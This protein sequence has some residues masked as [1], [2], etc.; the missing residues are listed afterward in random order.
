MPLSTIFQLHCI[1]WWSLLLVE[2]TGVPSENH[3]PFDMCHKL[4]MCNLEKETYEIKQLLINKNNSTYFPKIT[5]LQRTTQ[6]LFTCV[7]AKD[8]IQI[9]CTFTVCI[10]V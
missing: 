6:Y 4:Y 8:F 10:S 2:E 1:S 9:H 3:G 7:C 5:E